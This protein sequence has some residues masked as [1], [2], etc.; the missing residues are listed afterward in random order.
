MR[1]TGNRPQFHSSEIARSHCAPARGPPASPVLP[2]AGALKSPTCFQRASGWAPPGIVRGG[3][4][5]GNQCQGWTSGRVRTC[6]AHISTEPHPWPSSALFPRASPPA[7]LSSG[8]SLRLSH[9]LFPVSL[10]PLSCRPPACPELGCTVCSPPAARPPLD[11][12][13]YHW[14]S[15]RASGLRPVWEVWECPRV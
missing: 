3:A 7:S 8:T 2:P 5:L 12:G 13:P 6:P 9:P 1:G 14:L 4:V 10:E 11:P 15:C